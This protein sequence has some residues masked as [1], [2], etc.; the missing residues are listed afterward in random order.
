M[1]LVRSDHALGAFYRRLAART[2]KPKAM[3]AA[4]RKLAMLVYRMLK[5]NMPYHDISAAGY[6][7]K[8]LCKDYGDNDGNHHLPAGARELYSLQSNFNRGELLEATGIPL[9]SGSYV[10]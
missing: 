2:E 10:R 5:Y 4:A 7:A 1:A 3:T 9:C 8:H 6:G